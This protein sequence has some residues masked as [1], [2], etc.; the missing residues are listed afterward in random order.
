MMVKGEARETPAMRVNSFW[1][2][3]L[4][5]LDFSLYIPRMPSRLVNSV[6]IGIVASLPGVSTR[7]YCVVVNAVS[8]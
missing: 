6:T 8:S 3:A 7:E 2:V 5:A 1:P 4:R